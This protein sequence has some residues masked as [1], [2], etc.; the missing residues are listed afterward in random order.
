MSPGSSATYTFSAAKDA[1]DAKVE[2]R[3]SLL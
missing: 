2:L 3:D 1:D